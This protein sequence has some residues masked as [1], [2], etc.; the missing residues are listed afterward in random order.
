MPI[1]S[2]GTIQS[3]IEYEKKNTSS[4]YSVGKESKY[5]WI[6]KIDFYKIKMTRDMNVRYVK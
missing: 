2:N 4:N 6:E 5:R 1:N 3:I